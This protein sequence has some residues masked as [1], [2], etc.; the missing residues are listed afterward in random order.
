M[1]RSLKVG[2]ISTIAIVAI[3]AALT[4]AT[5][6][7]ESVEDVG[8]KGGTPE[9]ETALQALGETLNNNGNK[10]S[11]QAESGE[12]ATTESGEGPGQ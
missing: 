12:S 10:T 5:H 11:T 1:K 8:K 7:R 9:N 3:V 4:L 6:V 2:L